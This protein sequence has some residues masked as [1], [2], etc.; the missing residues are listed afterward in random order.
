MNAKNYLY[1][2]AYG[3][4]SMQRHV[5]IAPRCNIIVTHE[6]VI[7]ETVVWNPTVQCFLQCV[8]VSVQSE[9]FAICAA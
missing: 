8:D 5:Y 4:C 9:I 7:S 6:F 2:Y 1:S 3:L